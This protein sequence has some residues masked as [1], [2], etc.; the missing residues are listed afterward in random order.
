MAVKFLKRKSIQRVL[1]YFKRFY[2]QEVLVL[3][4]SHASVFKKE[5]LKKAFPGFFVSTCAVGGATISGLENPNSKTK[6]L[7]KFRKALKSARP[8]Y[9]VLLLGEVDTGFVIWYRAE[10]YQAPVA[11]M[12]EKAVNNYQA[13][14]AEVAALAPVICI[15]TPMPTI[16]DDNDWGEI[17]NIRNDINATQ[18][19]RTALTLAFNK[20]MA[21]YCQQ[22][23][24]HYLWL[25]NESLGPDGL[26]A[27]YLLNKDPCDHHYD[28]A[29][30]SGLLIKHLQDVLA[31]EG[32]LVAQP[33]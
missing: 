3:G 13:F 18:Q 9:I 8:A 31:V 23:G 21:S 20:Q 15:S 17:A 27:P 10:K 33:G 24:H 1:K 6:A 28:D 32:V 5:L 26:V 2:L 22:Q 19:Q 14:I 12:L 25:D 16:R 4:D 7:D 11:E 30:Y 29:T